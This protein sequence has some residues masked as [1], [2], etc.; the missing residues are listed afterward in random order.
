MIRNTI[1]RDEPGIIACFR[2]FDMA[3]TYEVLDQSLDAKS[4]FQRN[5][6]L[7][8]TLQSKVVSIGFSNF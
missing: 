6:Y 5:R 7:L 2:R 3:T 8:S 1:N 4:G